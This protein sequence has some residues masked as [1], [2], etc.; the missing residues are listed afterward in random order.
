M[1]ALGLVRTTVGVLAWE[2]TPQGGGPPGANTPKAERR[3]V[4]AGPREGS[5]GDSRA[6]GV[7]NH[8]GLGIV[9]DELATLGGC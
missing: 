5:N 8:P 1:R 2:A 9:E 6:Q 3:I 7:P 4:G